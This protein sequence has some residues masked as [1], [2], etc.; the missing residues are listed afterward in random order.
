MTRTSYYDPAPT[1][2]ATVSYDQP[3]EYY[4]KP[5]RPPPP[6]PK[7]VPGATLFDCPPPAD[8]EATTRW[9]TPATE[10]DPDV[11]HG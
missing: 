2:R 6:L 4:R 10:A 5:D 9:F 3:G 8:P 11:M 7:R 1:G